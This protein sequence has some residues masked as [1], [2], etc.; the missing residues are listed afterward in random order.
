MFAS[1]P[2]ARFVHPDDDAEAAGR[3]CRILDVHL[4]QINASEAPAALRRIMQFVGEEHNDTTIDSML[5][6]RDNFGTKKHAA[7][8][9]NR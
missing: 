4:K 6:F 8:R 9:K 7:V 2:R 3:R 1:R 5:A